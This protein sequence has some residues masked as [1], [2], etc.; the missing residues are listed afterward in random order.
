MRWKDRLKEEVS[1]IAFAQAAKD[2]LVKEL[3]F[4]V[5][6]SK[7]KRPLPARLRDFWHGSTE[8]RVEALALGL[9]LITFGLWKAYSAI[10]AVD[11]TSAPVLLQ[12]GPETITVIHQGV[13]LL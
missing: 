7:G 13:S 3:M 8:I 11:K 4:A 1:Q 9:C 6:K 10:F 5:E 12:L 2:Q